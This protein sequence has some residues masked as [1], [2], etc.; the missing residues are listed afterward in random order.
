MPTTGGVVVSVDFFCGLVLCGAV[1]LQLGTPLQVFS[2]VFTSLV[3]TKFFVDACSWDEFLDDR[4]CAR[5]LNPL[6]SSSDA[7]GSSEL[8]PE[9][10]QTS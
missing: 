6:G 1:L 9:L 2:V 5:M 8:N 7:L 3:E 4:C 10:N